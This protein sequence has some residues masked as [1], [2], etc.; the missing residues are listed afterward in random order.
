MPLAHLPS[1]SLLQD[2]QRAMSQAYPRYRWLSHCQ[3]ATAEQRRWLQSS[4]SLTQLLKTACNNQFSVQIL[5]QYYGRALPDEAALL[6]QD[7]S[8]T[9]FIR[10]VALCANGT[11]WVFACTLVPQQSLRGAGKRLTGLGDRPLGALLFNDPQLRR[12]AFE[13]RHLRVAHQPACWGRRSLFY[14]HGYPLLVSEVF[15]PT[16][17][18]VRCP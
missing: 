17:A 9:Q 11:P 13:F 15:L 10:E 1:E 3:T 12:S 5:R 4:G 2:V 7:P 6:E 18:S 14:V 16:M 8:A